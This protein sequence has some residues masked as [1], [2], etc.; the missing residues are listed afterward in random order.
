MSGGCRA[1]SR[2]RGASERGVLSSRPRVEHR[3]PVGLTEVAPAGAVDRQGT[4]RSTIVGV[5]GVSGRRT[6]SPGASD[7]HDLLGELRRRGR[8]P[9]ALAFRSSLRPALPRQ[10]ARRGRTRRGDPCTQVSTSR[11]DASPSPPPSA[12]RGR[13]TAR[14]PPVD[15]AGLPAGGQKLEARPEGGRQELSPEP[16]RENPT[17]RPTSGPC[18]AARRGPRPLRRGASGR[19]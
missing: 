1:S 16:G 7:R 8:C 19:R 14:P 18:G 12:S 3:G 17:P 11:N 9:V 15:E 10:L 2:R 13:R 4:H 6:H 5:P